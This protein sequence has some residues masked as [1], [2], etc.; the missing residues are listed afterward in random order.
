MIDI[1][2]GQVPVLHVNWRNDNPVPYSP[3]FQCGIRR[4]GTSSWL[5]GPITQDSAAGNTSKLTSVPGVAIPTTWDYK[6]MVDARL[7]MNGDVAWPDIKSAY[8]V[9]SGLGGFYLYICNYP[10]D[11]MLWY[12]EF[13]TVGESSW[14]TDN[15]GW[16]WL[17]DSLVVSDV[18]VYNCEVKAILAN[19]YEVPKYVYTSKFAA[20]HNVVTYTWDLLKNEFRSP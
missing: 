10:Y 2:R 16:R 4:S 8:R 3:K 5:D 12:G 15:K 20:M 19:I 7:I 6:V 14:R 11:V 1:R 18:D 9:V 13:R 17:Y